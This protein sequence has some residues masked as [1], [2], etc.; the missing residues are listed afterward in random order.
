M[1]AGSDQFRLSRG[2]ERD[3]QAICAAP[4]LVGHDRRRVG[5]GLGLGGVVRE[6]YD[7]AI[8]Q[9]D[10]APADVGRGVVLP[11]LEA[12]D[13]GPARGGRAAGVDA[14]YGSRWEPRINETRAATAGR[15]RK[16]LGV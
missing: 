10:Q 6:I 11:G 3:H 1:T 13:F 4:G 5:S 2:C 14:A 15:G 9:R 7:F 16:T 8:A 12:G